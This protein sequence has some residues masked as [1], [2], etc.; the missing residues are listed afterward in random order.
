MVWERPYRHPAWVPSP[1]E[2]FA[3]PRFQTSRE[4][5]NPIVNNSSLNE[6]LIMFNFYKKQVGPHHL[7]K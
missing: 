5:P 1:E 7:S 4:F 3:S 6:D 2:T